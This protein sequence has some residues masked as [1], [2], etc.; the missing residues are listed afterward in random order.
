MNVL[1]IPSL[2]VIAVLAG[3]LKSADAATVIFSDDF[4]SYSDTASMQTVWGA[5]GLGSLN[6]TFG[7]SGQ[8]MSHPGGTDNIITIGTQQATASE[9]LIYTVDIYDDGASA[10]KR[11]TAGLRSAGVANL[12]EMGMYDD[13][14]HYAVRAVLPGPN[15]V[16]FDNIMDDGGNPI[17]N[18]P[19]VGWHRFQVVLDG[20]DATFTLDLGSTGIVN[21]TTVLAASWHPN[22]VDSI[23]LGGPSSLSSAGGGGFYDNVSL[24]S[25]PEPTSTCLLMISAMT[26]VV[27][28]RRHHI[29]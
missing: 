16:A 7:N 27:I 18:A 26:M 12:L 15:W 10:N 24:V 6:T 8:S 9:P 19:V 5:A 17:A 20:T 2:V 23:R 28:R 13:P 25:V 22:G 14:N 1:K 21:A 11:L 29:P 4:E 3:G